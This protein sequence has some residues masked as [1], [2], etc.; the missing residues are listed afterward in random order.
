MEHQPEQEIWQVE[1]NSEIYQGSFDELSKWIEE[2]SLLRA[3][4]VRKGNLRW[5]EAG[6]VPSL[7]AVFSAVENGQPI[8]VPVAPTE[9]VDTTN[10]TV[11][12]PLKVESDDLLEVNAPV[13][14]SAVASLSEE[15]AIPAAVSVPVPS[16]ATN[17]TPKATD[18]TFCSVHADLMTAYICTS[19]NASFC[20]GCPKTYASVKICPA[21]GAMCESVGQL[22]KKR[23]EEMHH[24]MSSGGFGFGDFAASIGHPFRFG[25]SLVVGGAMY[26]ALSTGQAVAG[27]GGPFMWVAALF[28]F[29]FANMLMFGVLSNTAEAFAKGD[30]NSNFMPSF[31][32][33]SVW[34][35][36]LRP[37]F[38]SIA[39]YV[40]SFGPFIAM[41]IVLAFFVLG[42]VK[43]GVIPGQ[44][45]AQSAVPAA[46]ELPNAAKGA[47]QSERIRDLLN[48]QANVQ[49][50]RVASATQSA[51]S[52]NSAAGQEDIARRQAEL[53]KEFETLAKQAQTQRNFPGA[54]S[55]GSEG[56]LIESF[57]RRG[58]KYML[59]AGVFLLWGLIYF[60]AA[61]IVAGYTNSIGATINPLVGLD[62]MWNLG[63]DYIRLLLIAAA[64]AFVGGFAALIV[65]TVLSP[66]NLPLLGNI[67]AKFVTSFIGFYLWAVFA[68]SIGFLL[69]KSR[70]K[71]RLPS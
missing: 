9:K 38:L 10:F 40:V 63:L 64:L 16:N 12:S 21:C 3:D 4:K 57:V 23:R 24:S 27:Y 20:K 5:I 39:A 30:T 62:T 22:E 56:A 17:S 11:S 69:F 66:F 65:V 28:C 41:M 60:P 55:Q 67:P 2:G 48:K 15:P 29:L 36:I 32:D 45:L 18:P 58:F 54:N 33:F 13:P 14:P 31:E 71:L 61:C 6:R 8:P 46:S 19:C 50:D 47:E 59:L 43:D 7:A 51:E 34:D 44:G 35:D 53:N 52:G 70:S 25:T 37:F 26:A 68:C 1:A 42:A 49:R